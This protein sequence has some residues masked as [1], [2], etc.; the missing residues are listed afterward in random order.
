MPYYSPK[1]FKRMNKASDILLRGHWLSRKT[2]VQTVYVN[3]SDG[4]KLRLL[5]CK[6]RNGQYTD[7]VTGLL[8]IHGGGYAMGQPEQDFLFASFFSEDASCITVLPDYTLSLQ[9]PYPAALDDCYLALTWMY[10]NAKEL[11]IN[12][13]QIFVG[14]ESAGGGLTAAL[15]LYARDKGEV[16]VAFQ[17]PLYPMLD[18]RQITGTSKNNDA[19]VW[20]TLSNE[21]AWKM[22][23]EGVEEPVPIY[24]APGRATNL[25]KLPPACTYVGDIEPFFDE[26][27]DYFERLKSCNVQTHIKVFAGCFHAFDLFGYPTELGR[28]ARDFL[29]KTFKY[30]QEHYFK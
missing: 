10:E 19:P 2:K 23:L 18:D 22:Y 21:A 27:V 11:G 3:R 5:I 16:P 30:A 28:Q 1:T 26:T 14:G 7:P 25:E 8:W 15:C 17:M 12:E 4:T 6:A 29:K 24:A 13:K 9:K 20:N